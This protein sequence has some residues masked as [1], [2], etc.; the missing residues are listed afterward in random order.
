MHSN[1]KFA[2]WRKVAA[3]LALLALADWLFYGHEPG[4]TLGA[5]AL[6]W[7]LALGLAVPALRRGGA[8]T[9]LVIAGLFGAV[10]VDDP[11]P[12]AWTM[13]WTALSS[14]ALL[15]RARFD[16]AGRWA[17]RLAAHGL[18]GPF[19]PLADT[20]R[21]GKLGSGVR[22]RSAMSLLVLPVAGGALF[23]AL[24]AGANPLIGAALAELEPPSLGA[25]VARTLFWGVV[26]AII[27]PSLRP[28]F[29]RLPELEVGRSPF[30][31]DLRVATLV[32]SLATFNL[33]FA[34]ENV[35]DLVFLWSGAPLPP[36]VTL[37][38]YAH[39]GAYTLIATALL[40]GTFV[41][42]ALRPGSAAARS[43]L[44]RRLVV[45]WIVQNVLLVAS[46][47]RRTLDYVDAYQ[48]TVLR[49]S[50][51]AWMALVA[52]GLVLICWRI[53]RAKS[54]AWLINV[55]ALA[56]ALVLGMA[57]VVDLGATAAAWNVREASEGERLDLCYLDRLGVSALIPLIE[58]ERRAGGPVL[59]D[60]AAYLRDLAL[61]R[62][63]AEQADWH[64]WTARGARRLAAAQAGIDPHAPPALVAPNGRACGGAIL[65]PPARPL[66]AEAR[67]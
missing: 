52:V 24:F 20:I 6:A 13:F 50:A 38:E 39:R 65:P 22:V 53:L 54:A 44:V 28:W 67:P 36:G 19:R 27:W 3:A 17:I 7:I 25:V 61:R 26:L 60:R 30:V 48:M 10:L 2:F 56:G 62:L 9:A 21:L 8:L 34:V 45:V 18:S 58:L 29:P 35:L 46:S 42:V 11:S 1:Q 57:S 64:S 23:I 51:L 37:A 4:S 12:L 43:G 49:L 33:I 63:R 14:A 16:S 47:A 15:T 31:P 59:R 41:L 55:N 5:F 32:V 66:T 40:A